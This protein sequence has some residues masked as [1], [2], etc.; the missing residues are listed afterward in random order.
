[1]AA[2]VV[3][4]L[5]GRVYS[6]GTRVYITRP[7]AATPSTA[8]NF[9]GGLKSISGPSLKREIVDTTELAP[10]PDPLPGGGVIEE[11]YYWKGKQP[12]DKEVDEITFTLNMTRATYTLLG[13][14]FGRDETVNLFIVFRNGDTYSFSAFVSTLNMELEDNQ[15]VQVPVGFTIDGP[16]TYTSAS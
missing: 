7:N 4:A 14:V 15:L 16:V 8:Q 11:Q 13:T 1:M 9:L 6:K 5:K 2:G 10:A 12:G 3:E